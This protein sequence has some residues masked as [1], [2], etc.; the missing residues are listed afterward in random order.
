MPIPV[1]CS[2]CSARLNAPDAAAGK[3]VK[4]P[5]CQK[6]VSVPAAS[7]GFEVVED[8]PAPVPPKKAAPVDDAPRRKTARPT[9]RD[10][11]ED[12]RPA[13][14]R[15]ARDNRDDDDRPRKKTRRAVEEDDD[16]DDRPRGR[17]RQS[18]A[19]GGAGLLIAVAV[20]GLLLLLAGGGFAVY[21]F[22]FRDKD[23]EVAKTGGTGTGTG[24]GTPAQ[25]RIM[26]GW[27]E[28]RSELWGFRTNFPWNAP[29]NEDYRGGM[30][31]T[32]TALPRNLPAVV[33]ATSVFTDRYGKSANI[34]QRVMVVAVRFRPKAT[35]EGRDA[36]LDEIVRAE[37]DAKGT[38]SEPKEVTWGGRAAREI[39]FTSEPGADGKTRR[40]TLRR[41]V[42]D[43]VGYAAVVRDNTGELPPAEVA[44]FFDGFQPTPP[45]PAP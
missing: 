5:K 8:E 18:E 41:L 36:A 35:A 33:R 15:P 30:Y 4:C 37:T 34:E 28:Y 43:D 7:P 25:P 44:Q 6:T 24:A 39:T 40:V 27:R 32:P 13:A 19:R 20:A 1:V 45:K 26:N 31:N 10:P 14:K 9:R 42:T 17:K 21:W 38:T 16:E 2:G 22:G 11:D 23:Q 29:L 12:E 3:A